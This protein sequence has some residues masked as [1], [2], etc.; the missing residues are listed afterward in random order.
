MEGYVTDRRHHLS[1]EVYVTTNL[2]V[3]YID[4]VTDLS[5]HCI[6]IKL[7]GTMLATHKLKYKCD[8]TQSRNGKLKGWTCLWLPYAVAAKVHLPLQD[9]TLIYFH[10]KSSLMGTKQ[11]TSRAHMTVFICAWFRM[12]DYLITTNTGTNF[13]HTL[14]QQHHLYRRDYIQFSAGWFLMCLYPPEKEN[15]SPM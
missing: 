7:Q 9:A 10:L 11:S 5:K 3:T 2:S 6:L 13:L 4:T 8:I 1:K 12:E 14:V 15:N